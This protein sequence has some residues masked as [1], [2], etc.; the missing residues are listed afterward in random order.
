MDLIGPKGWNLGGIQ[1]GRPRGHCW[2]ALCLGLEFGG[3]RSLKV[4]EIV[5][6]AESGGLI[7][8]NSSKG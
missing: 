8:I 5:W 1:P 6:R 2:H 4:K 7:W 3:R